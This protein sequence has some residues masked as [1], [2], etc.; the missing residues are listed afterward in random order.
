MAIASMYG[1]LLALVT[2]R[3]EFYFKARL[4]NCWRTIPFVDVAQVLN[5]FETHGVPMVLES[6]LTSPD[7][8]DPDTFARISPPS[9][10][11]TIRFDYNTSIVQGI[12]A[13]IQTAMA[14]GIPI[15]VGRD[16]GEE[17]AQLYQEYFDAGNRAKGNINGDDKF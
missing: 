13:F 17:D 5:T 14:F 3:R 8:Y 16:I 4:L 10:S 6:T 9:S 11:E 15:Q 2:D 1:Q 7:G 12:I